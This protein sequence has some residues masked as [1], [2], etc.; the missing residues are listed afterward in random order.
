MCAAAVR[1]GILDTI[2]VEK[3]QLSLVSG[4]IIVMIS[5][6]VVSEGNDETLLRLIEKFKGKDPTDLCTD[7]LYHAAEQV[8]GN[9][10]DDMSVM[11]CAMN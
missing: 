7:I 1:A 11:V 4:D 3:F 6:G 2:N 9:N 10:Q 8:K 5:D